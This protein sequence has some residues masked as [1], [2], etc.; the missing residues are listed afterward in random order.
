M[1]SGAA[2]RSLREREKI[3][4]RALWTLSDLLPGDPKAIPVV[5]VLDD[6]DRQD[7]ADILMTPVVKVEA[8]RRFV[9]TEFHSSNLQIVRDVSIPEPWRERFLQASIGSTRLE[10]GPYLHDLEKFINLWTQ[11]NQHLEEH[12]SAID[13]YM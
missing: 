5:S 4:R 7:E 13:K 12:R 1:S 8:L 11:E 3:R 2:D 10:A 6:I 9:V